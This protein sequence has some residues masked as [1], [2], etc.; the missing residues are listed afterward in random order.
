MD[1]LQPPEMAD[2]KQ[3]LRWANQGFRE[4]D[5][6]FELPLNVNLKEYHYFRKTKGGTWEKILTLK[7]PKTRH[8]ASMVAYELLENEL[9]LYDQSPFLPGL[10]VTGKNGWQVM[11]SYIAPLIAIVYNQVDNG[12]NFGVSINKG[13]TYIFCHSLSNKAFDNHLDYFTKQIEP[14]SRYLTGLAKEHKGM[15]SF[16]KAR[17]CEEDDYLNWGWLKFNDGYRISVA[18]DPYYA[19]FQKYNKGIDLFKSIESVKMS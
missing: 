12:N 7:H 10:R 14:L 15:Q 8:M 19:R 17:G 5:F 6:S 13:Q 2:K 16:R 9:N 18:I 1:T 11:T 3:E 4:F